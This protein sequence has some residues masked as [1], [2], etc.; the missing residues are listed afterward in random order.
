MLACS[1]PLTHLTATHPSH[2]SA[3]MSLDL[4][5]QLR[6]IHQGELEFRRMLAHFD[7]PRVQPAP[8]VPS[9]QEDP[10]MEEAISRHLANKTSLYLD[11]HDPDP[12]ETAR[13]TQEICEKYGT[14]QP[15]QFNPPPVPL[16]DM[17]QPVV[18]K[19]KKHK[20]EAS[21]KG[22]EVRRIYRMSPQGREKRRQTKRMA[23]LRYEHAI[24]AEG[25][26]QAYN[27]HPLE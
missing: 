2:F 18:Y 7:K 16:L 5:A 13:V 26:A 22:L 23:R 20:Y 10:V 19:S 11:W 14:K 17:R 1:P 12:V 9:T 3:A 21:T 6:A 8:H 25:R 15:K 4:A 24:S 27:R